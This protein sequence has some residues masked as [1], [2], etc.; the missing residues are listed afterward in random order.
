MNFCTMI[1]YPTV[2]QFPTVSL[3]SLPDMS[4][5]LITQKSI[6]L[7]LPSLSS[8]FSLIILINYPSTFPC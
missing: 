2:D 6:A 1:T 5:N 4:G 7:F 3:H 8:P